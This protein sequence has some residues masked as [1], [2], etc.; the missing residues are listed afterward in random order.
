[1]N[2][3]L[4]AVTDAKARPIGFFMSTGQVSDYTG[5]ATLLATFRKRAG[6]L[7]MRL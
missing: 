6:C 5:A 3:K 4:D 2:T 1:M 7:P